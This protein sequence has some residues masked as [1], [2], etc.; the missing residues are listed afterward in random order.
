MSILDLLPP[1]KPAVYLVNATG[2]GYASSHSTSGQQPDGQRQVS[3][4]F[5]SADNFQLY[6]AP[7]PVNATRAPP[8][9]RDQDTSSAYG[10]TLKRSSHPADRLRERTPLSGAA[11]DGLQRKVDLLKLPA[12]DYYLRLRHPDGRAVGYA[13]FKS[14]PGRKLPALSTVLSSSMRPRGT[15]IEQRLQKAAKYFTTDNLDPRPEESL[16]WNRKQH[17]IAGSPLAGSQVVSKAFDA[18]RAFGDTATLNTPSQD[19]TPDLSYP[20]RDDG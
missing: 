18:M 9:L 4:G 5:D 13:A 17:L 12:G 19:V 15:D 20:G 14:V 7:E 16:A 2:P 10:E 6:N 3:E 1:G 11:I 8:P